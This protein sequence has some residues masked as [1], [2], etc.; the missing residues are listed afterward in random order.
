MNKYLRFA[1]WVFAGIVFA[2]FTAYCIYAS[3]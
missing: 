2:A 1:L 3:L